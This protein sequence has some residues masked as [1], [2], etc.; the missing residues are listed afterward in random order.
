MTF[1][2][3]L[4]AVTQSLSAQTTYEQLQ[5]ISDIEPGA[6][7]VLGLE[8]VGFHYDGITSWGLVEQPSNQ[9]PVYYT[10]TKS[11]DGS[12]FTAQATIQGATRYLQVLSSNVFKMT[13]DA[14]ETTAQLVIGTS[15]VSGE[16]FAVASNTVNSRHLRINGE[17]GLRAYGHDVG[18]MAYFY[19]ELT[20][21]VSVITYNVTFNANG[22]DFVANSHF[23]DV[24][25]TKQPGAYVLPSATK[26]GYVFNGWTTADSSTPLIGSYMV[27][28]NV[29]FTAS[30]T[31]NG[32]AADAPVIVAN[33]IQAFFTN[34][35]VNIPFYIANQP[36]PVGSLSATVIS[37]G[38][39]FTLANSQPQSSPVTLSCLV[40]TSNDTEKSAIIRL[41]YTY[42]GGKTVTKDV[43]VTQGRSYAFKEADTESQLGTYAFENTSNYIRLSADIALNNCLKIGD[44][45]NARNVTLDLNGHQLSRHLNA[46]DANGHVIEVFSGSTLTIIDT[47]GGGII[48]GG[49]ANN[50][51][52]ICNS[53]TLNFCAGTITNCKGGQQGGGIKNNSGCTVNMSGGTIQNCWGKDGGGIYN[54]AGGIV[55]MTGGVITGNESTSG[56]GGVVNYGTITI[57]GGTISN[58]LATTRGGGIWNGGALTLGAA[59]IEGNEAKVAGGG[60]F[61][62]NGYTVTLYNTVIKNNTSADAG[63]IYVENGGVANLNNI[64]VRGNISAQHG[65]G[66]IG[67]HGTLNIHGATLEN[68][69]CYTEGGGIWNGGV[70][71]MEGTVRVMD[72]SK[73][74]GWPSNLYCTKNHLVTVIGSLGSSVISVSCEGNSGVITTGYKAHNATTNHFRSDIPEACNL[75]VTDD[76]CKL[77]VRNDIVYYVSCNWDEKKVVKNISWMNSEAVTILSGADEEK[78]EEL[79]DPY[80][81]YVVKDK[82]VIRKQLLVKNGTVRLILCDGAKL[83]APIGI[84]YGATLKIYGQRNNSGALDGSIHVEPNTTP[85]TSLDIYGGNISANGDSQCAGIGG[86]ETSYGDISIY[87]G[88]V[89]AQGGSGA[90]GIG[91][92]QRLFETDDISGKIEIYGGEVYAEGGYH[93]DRSGAGIGGGGGY[94]GGNITIYGGKVVARGGNDA[95]GIGSGEESS[96]ENVDGGTINISGGEVYAYGNDEGAGIG[97]GQYAAMGVINITGGYVEVTGGDNRNAIS[98]DD[99]THGRNSLTIGTSLRVNV[100][101]AYTQNPQPVNASARTTA[102]MSNRYALI[103]PCDHENATFGTTMTD[104]NHSVV[105]SY[106]AVA[107]EPHA[108]GTYGECAACHLV[109]LGDRT[110]NTDIISHWDGQTKHILLSGRTLY[111]DGKWNTLTL[112]F[113]V[114]LSGSALD[115]AVARTVNNASISGETLNL[116]FDG[117]V[118]ELKAGTPYI[119]KWI[120]DANYVDDNAHNIVNPIFENVTV[121]AT[122]HSY[123]NG[124]SGEGSVRFVG[125]RQSS[126]FAAADNSILLMGAENTL[127]YVGAGTGIG[128]QRAYFQV[129]DGVQQA[130]QLKAFNL[131]FGESETTGIS[132]TPGQSMNGEGRGEWFTLDGRKLNAQP[133]KPGIYVVNKKKVV[134]P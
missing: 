48:S 94:S 34:T 89:T 42:G 56:G 49:W 58:N 16:N 123:D 85:C 99:T 32:A 28:E 103:Q 69:Q 78:K 119:I 104:V 65:G 54:A 108:F 112:P 59:T 36:D 121:D 45:N 7:Y 17:S 110:D 118:D 35:S 44:N 132:L 98:G 125:T 19:K 93:L 88:T 106:C 79:D 29:D 4:M 22:G 101:S 46:V 128:A 25:N 52:G 80:G 24:T 62:K 107:A 102:S 91:S 96:Y 63:A 83:T 100:A 71:N 66:G 70:I 68:N 11:A 37:G 90:A 9:P 26:S 97:G 47:A 6:K 74:S 20:N 12:Y 82:N 77:T 8:G 30:F 43:T 126:T 86:W 130:R 53:G 133:T 31:E 122:D 51:G 131:S 21:G 18:E 15:G 75:S 111:K 50:G 67:N 33:D 114:T 116:E 127:Y 84:G 109:S 113:D 14:E 129:G 120:A 23:A 73:L 40:N 1:L 27:S 134:I 10:L 5:S 13:T 39:W 81:W 92:G 72:N 124:V 115:G 117:A 60:I 57:I 38:D 61:L 95:A 55:N 76:E 41:T 64:I 3:L 105:C 87:G 2:L